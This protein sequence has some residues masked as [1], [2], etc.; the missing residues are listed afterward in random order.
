MLLRRSPV[1]ALHSAMLFKKDRLKSKA[2]V[3]HGIDLDAAHLPYRPE[4]IEYV[5]RAK[6]EGRRVVLATGS[7]RKFAEAVA[8]HLGLFDAVFATEREGVNLISKHKLERIIA[9]AG[10]QPFEYL[11]DSHA[12]VVVF[13]GSA[14]AGWVGGRKLNVVASDST[15]VHRLAPAHNDDPID[16]LRMLRPH[17]WAVNLLVFLPLVIANQWVWNL[18]TRAAVLSFLSMCAMASAGYIIADL[19]GMDVDQKHARRHKRPIPSGAVTLSRIAPIA[20]ILFTLAVIVAACVNWQ[21]VIAVL[22][23]FAIALAFA[24]RMRFTLP[25]SIA[26]MTALLA[27]RP[28]TGS[29][30]TG[31]A[32]PPAILVGCIVLFAIIAYFKSDRP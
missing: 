2:I 26:A 31:L 4:V 25:T 16:L 19:L 29:A 15:Q 10:G 1:A 7:T 23:Y 6:A 17:Y 30:A 11:G 28:I 14:I 13:E 21:T 9:D 8:T 5:K 18:A 3:A 32:L 12:D 24:M 27:M 22:A 20:V